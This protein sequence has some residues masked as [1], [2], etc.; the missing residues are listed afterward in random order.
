[1]R[2]EC[3]VRRSPRSRRI[4]LTI[5]PRNQALLY[6]PSRCSVRDALQFLHSQGDWLLRHLREAPPRLTL[7]QFLEQRPYLHGSGRSYQVVLQVTRVRPFLVF[8]PEAQE[9]VLR[10][11]LEGEI[12]SELTELL[13][14]FAEQVLARRTR[15]LAAKHGVEVGRVSIRNQ[16][17]RWGSCSNQRT[18][19]L[20]WRLVLIPP[21]LQDY[22]ILHELAHLSEMNHSD[23]FWNL[24]RRY[25]PLAD[26]HDREL[27]QAA[28]LIMK[29]A[30]E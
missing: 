13:W 24:L 25:D 22:V 17:S 26:R 8:L 29:L 19:S 10:Y 4:R 1:M 20:N 14:T 16:A 3:E 9:V 27:N 6:V 18:V 2:V 28:G 5:G 11:R 23:R 15:E 7:A 12:E 21:A 30:R